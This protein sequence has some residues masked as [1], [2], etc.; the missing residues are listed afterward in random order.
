MNVSWFADSAC[1]QPGVDPELFFPVGEAG[2]A[3]RQIAE[4]KAICARCPV[5][6]Q[7]RDWALRTGE[8]D[9]IWGGMTLEE[10]RKARQAS[11]LTAPR[12]AGEFPRRHAGELV[13]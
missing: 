5:A 9:G 10:R 12:L 1:R 13:S 2:L 4:A 7:C 11:T 6:A 8:T 3:S